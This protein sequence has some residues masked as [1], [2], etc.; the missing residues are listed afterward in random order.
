MGQ[1]APQIPADPSR[2][3]SREN[4]VAE[5]YPV[6]RRLWGSFL[7]DFLIIVRVF[8]VV[9]FGDGRESANALKALN[10]EATLPTRLDPFSAPVA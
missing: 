3:R 8:L 4:R 2:S 9:V 6:Y 7:G 5:S 1:Q 10:E